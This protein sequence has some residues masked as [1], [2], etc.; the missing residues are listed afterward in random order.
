VIPIDKTIELMIMFSTL[1]LLVVT[2]R[3]VK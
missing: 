3:G 2:I 1:M